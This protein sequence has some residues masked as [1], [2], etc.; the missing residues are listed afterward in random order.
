MK[1]DKSLQNRSIP[2]VIL[3]LSLFSVNLFSQNPLVMNQFTADPT[4]R[5][6]EDKLYVYPSHDIPCKEGQGFI[7]FCMPDYH[8][9][10]SENL[11]EWEDHGVIFS[12]NNV[13]WVEPGSF[14]M[15]APDCVFK[16]GKYYH[17]FPANS[18]EKI[19]GKGRR[20]GV[21]VSEKPYGPFV[22]ESDFI[23]GIWGIDPNVFIDK[24]G[25]AYIYWTE[26]RVIYGALLKENMVE[27][28]SVPKPMKIKGIG[29]NK[30]IEGPFMFERKGIYYMTFPYIPK[31]IEQIVY[32]T[33]NNPLG[34]FEY[35]NVIMKESSS[36]C[37]TN[38][39]SIVEY[40]NQ[41]YLFYHHNDL[42]PDFDKNRSIK[43]DSLFFDKDGLIEEIVPSRRGIG[44]SDAEKMIQI[45]RY[46][47]ISQEG[48]STE[49]NDPTQTFYGWKVFFKRAESW[50]QY[51]KVEF[52]NSKIKILNLKVESPDGGI[53]EVRLN[54]FDG[55]LVATIDL[56]KADGMRAISVKTKR[57]K[58]GTYDLFIIS[59]SKEPFAVDWLQF[60]Q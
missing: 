54:A 41:W 30:F 5:V 1:N 18:L 32:A 53:C 31:N 10:S 45:D 50:L 3:V 47:K 51:N 24:D 26:N 16:N 59:K 14:R 15:W 58:S 38:H 23:E 46:S 37:Y 20:I 28:A 34:P 27:L 56:E 8:V 60:I 25:K 44:V 6:F 49:F 17:Y 52:V 40:K 29:K 21:A 9:F 12:H 4:V 48:V 7:G 42:S 19:N 13:P 57:V 39:Q 35:Q 22:P 43:A 2:F 11:T 55:P 36:K 33:S